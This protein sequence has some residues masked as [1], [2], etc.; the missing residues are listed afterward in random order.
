[1]NKQTGIWI[2]FFHEAPD[3][4]KRRTFAAV[5]FQGQAAYLACSTLSA[6][7]QY[8][9]RKG[10]DIALHRAVRCFEAMNTG[11]ITTSQKGRFLNS[12]GKYRAFRIAALP[13]SA[14]FSNKRSAVLMLREAL[15]RD[16]NFRPAPLKRTAPKLKGIMKD[17]QK[18][19]QQAAL[20]FLVQQTFG[21]N[22]EAPNDL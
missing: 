18:I 17:V 20:R 16:H 4:P 21:K 13:G 22:E 14:V 9:R 2:M 3:V 1:M 12:M 6:K 15:I 5:V 8:N 11:L 19:V 7:D 10:N